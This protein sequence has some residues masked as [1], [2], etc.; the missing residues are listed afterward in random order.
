MYIYLSKIF[1]SL[2]IFAFKKPTWLKP[3]APYTF[4]G[5]ILPVIIFYVVNM[6]HKDEYQ[7]IIILKPVVKGSRIIYS[8]QG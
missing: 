4:W 3:S 2:T 7:V 6:L 1:I 8:V 5:I